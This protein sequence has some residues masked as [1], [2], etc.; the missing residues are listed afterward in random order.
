MADRTGKCGESHDEYAGSDC[1]LQFV[2]KDACED[3][4]HHHAA[5]C[6]D[7]SA[8]E[9]DHEAADNGL[10]E[11]SVRIC[12]CHGLFGG[13]DRFYDKLDSKKQ[14][15]EYREVSHGLVGHK[16]CNK[17]SEQ[18]HTQHGDHHDDTVADIKILIFSIRVGADGAGKD[19]ACKGDAY[20]FVGRH[21]KKCDQHGADDRCCAHSGES[22]SKSCAGS[23]QKADDKFCKHI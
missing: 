7:K 2:A 19:I 17:A 15:H 11:S 14:G 1:G 8:D 13:H 9:A 6:A 22:G 4:Q 16:A 10:D 21:V 20:G 12:T 18:G 23:G 3:E 5:A